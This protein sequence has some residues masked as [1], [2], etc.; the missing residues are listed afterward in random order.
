MEHW[1]AVSL[2]LN[3]A[4]Q[5]KVASGNLESLKNLEN[6]RVPSR[7]ARPAREAAK[8]AFRNWIGRFLKWQQWQVNGSHDTF[9]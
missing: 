2:N 8:L 5:L 4:E 3:F 1:Q 7:G 9:N 6:L